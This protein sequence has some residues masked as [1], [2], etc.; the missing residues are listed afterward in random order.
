M[1]R[2][3]IIAALAGAVGAVSNAFAA[4][5]IA[6][7]NTLALLATPAR[8]AVACVLALLLPLIFRGMPRWSAMLLALAA[9]T[10]LPSLNAKLVL[11]VGAP[12]QTVLVLNAVYA[13]VTTLVYLVAAGRHASHRG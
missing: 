3:F 5:V 4:G 1:T 12:W 2:Y 9:L 13:G 10:F 6:G 8:Y 11:G 7:A